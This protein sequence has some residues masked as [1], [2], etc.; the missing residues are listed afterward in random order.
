M[1]FRSVNPDIPCVVLP[2]DRQYLESSR[3]VKRD[4][5][6]RNKL[7]IAGVK[8]FRPPPLKSGNITV[9]E[10]KEI[11]ALLSSND[12]LLLPGTAAYHAAI[13]TG[14]LLYN[15]KRPGAV[16]VPYTAD[17]IASV[18]S[19][20]RENHILLTIKNGGHSFAAY[21]L[22]YGGI[23]ID[24]TFFKGVHIDDKEDI[25]TIQAG[26]VWMDVY[27]A[28]Y[29]RDPSYIVVGG[30]CSTVGV[31]GFTLGGGLSAFSRS[32]GLGIDN[33]TEMTVVTA[34]GNVL[35][36]HDEVDDDEKKKLFW[37]MRGGGGGNFGV[38]VEF[39]TKLHRVN[40]S[41]A[42][43]AYGPM[44]W[45]L[46]DS[47]ARERF[48]AAMDAFNSRE[49]PAELVINA[50]WQY[51]DGKLWGEMTVIYNGKLDKCLEILDPLLE[52]QPTVFDV[53][54]MQWHDCVVIEHGHDVE[55]LIYY[56]CASFTFG[57]GAI[58]PAVTNT[59][60]S[61]MEEANKLLGDNGKAYILWDMAGHATTTVAK[62][63]TPYYWREG[64]YVGCFKIQWQHRG[65][66]ASSLAFA[67]EV[68]RRL[69]PYAIEGKA[70]YVN[71]I[72]STVQNWPYAYYGN[73]YARLQAIKKYWDPTDFFHFP[74][75]ITPEIPKNLQS[76]LKSY[77]P[78]TSRT[79]ER[80]ANVS[81]T[82][83]I[84]T[85]QHTPET[86]VVDEHRPLTGLEATA[87]MWDQ[88][89]FSDPEKLWNMEEFDSEKVLMAIS[90][91]RTQAE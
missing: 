85:V 23:V 28:L 2:S 14:N 54:E 11:R 49:W 69:L 9:K 57:E 75:S 67:E 68:K 71:Y 86:Q 76:L 13:F 51:K 58:K 60:I 5:E 78:T 34:A 32:Y 3:A 84:D 62:D 1:A 82:S 40:D 4:L 27:D 77:V 74:Q 10:L 38:L 79:F 39:K 15:R 25:V 80:A 48:E 87:A 18:V 44:S 20:A 41:D 81:L 89:S 37:A 16:V 65:M 83:A 42:K 17:E 8:N 73:N 46:S 30:R 70:A 50:I 63:A 26:C 6:R 43:V 35:T 72:D 33:V 66:T 56:H 64:I 36:I 53:K 55:S 91:D 24:L 59:I 21:C 61:L 7:V 12:Q 88:Y 45:D 90:G 47:D 52:F 22:N 19:Y 31:S 29:K